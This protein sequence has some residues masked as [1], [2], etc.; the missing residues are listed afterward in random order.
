MSAPTLFY[1]EAAGAR[2]IALSGDLT[3]VTVDGTEDVL[4]GVQWHDWWV[5]G[6]AGD[7]IL[8]EMTAIVK[9]NNGATYTV[10]PY[11]DGVPQTT[12][13]VVVTG[14]VT[15]PTAVYPLNTDTVRGSRFA[16]LVQQ[17]APRT[18]DFEIIDVGIAYYP[19]RRTP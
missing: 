12:Q 2:V 10:T 9:T 6:S 3:Q 4:L 1:G 8:R 7:A 17:V 14:A 19:L 18:G 13:T 11:V 15:Q 16:V 5:A